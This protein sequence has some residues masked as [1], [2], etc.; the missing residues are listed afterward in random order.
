MERNAQRLLRLINQ[1]LDLSKLEAG[2][3]KLQ[4]SKQNIVSFVKGIA[5]SFESSA[6]K[7]DI[8]LA[9]EVDA[10][11]IEMYF[12]RDKLEKV[13]VNLLSNAF[14]FTPEGGRV[15][16]SLRRDVQSSTSLS[17][18]LNVL[19]DWLVMTVVDTGIG[20][21]KDQLD[22]VFDR[23]YQ[24]DAS[25]KREQEGSGI[26]LA[27]TKELIE[28]HC[29]SIH[30]TSEEGRGTTFTVRLPL[31]REHLKDD[32]VV[33]ENRKGEAFELSDLPLSHSPALPLLPIVG[34]DKQSPAAASEQPAPLV[35]IIEDNADVRAYIKSYLVPAYRIEEAKDGMDGI[36]KAI[37]L[38]PD[39]IISDVMMPKMNGYEVCG[40]LKLNEKTSHI[41]I[42]L[43]T[44]KAG[45]ESKIEGLETGADDY[46]TKPFDASELLVRMRNLIELRR[47]LRA[48]FS[49]GHV[50]KP[51]EIAVTSIDD[52][53]LQKAMAVVEKRI[54]DENFSVDEF[55]R[56]VGM[57]RSQL[58][59]KL[60]AL[61]NQAPSDFIRY[62]RLHRAKELLEKNVGTVSEIAFAVGFT[63]VAYF[64][65]CFKEQFGVVAS[66]CLPERRM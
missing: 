60:T 34:D 35:L 51:G 27:L 64:S 62:M 53:F 42:I 66:A 59:R 47:K 41:P 23:F 26:G 39:L 10:E 55:A 43:L 8:T 46:L 1:L 31:G 50:L 54:G 61:T 36:E 18:R 57:S 40:R 29:G 7:R 38:I 56:E 33:F 16:V 58:H 37:N 9:V 48:K 63:S 3:M 22:R 6:G 45:Q 32:E 25:Q 30:V 11:E 17:T 15:V 12:D 28:L 19:T 65:K 14:K 5:R 24:V 2:G 21:P 44:A 49:V 13:L 52:Q 20:I 4:A